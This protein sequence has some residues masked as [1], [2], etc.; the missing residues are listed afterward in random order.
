[1]R[2]FLSVLTSVSLLCPLAAT[3]K[4]VPVSL[5]ASLQML[6]DKKEDARKGKS[7]RFLERNSRAQMQKTH[8][9]YR[10]PS[11]LNRAFNTYVHE[12]HGL[13]IGYPGDWK[14]LDAFMGTV[15]S[16]LSPQTDPKDNVTENINIFVEQNA[17]TLRQATEKA[18]AQLQTLENFAM[19]ELDKNAIIAS[20]PAVSMVYSA[21][22]GDQTLKFKQVWTIHKNALYIFTFAASP[23]TYKEYGRA[24]EKMLG[25]LSLD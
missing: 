16:F 3:A 11:M 21:G 10:R 14:T 8:A 6:S 7:R 12:K 13:K 20:R 1:M 24:F 15:V 22:S 4:S 23:S 19:H 2:T 5:Q 18:M 17:T 9:R 25:T